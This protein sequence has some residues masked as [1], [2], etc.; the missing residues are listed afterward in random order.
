MQLRV[1][2]SPRR[3]GVG[4]RARFLYAYAAYRGEDELGRLMAG[5]C[6]SGPGQDA[7]PAAEEKGTRPKE[8]PER[9]G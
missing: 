2:R 1:R 7:R 6:E 8:R 3:W 4:R 9:G 5:L